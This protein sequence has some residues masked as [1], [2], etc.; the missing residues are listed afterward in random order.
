MDVINKTGLVA[1]SKEKS[2]STEQIELTKLSEALLFTSLNSIS[3]SKNLIVVYPENIF[4]SATFLGYNFMKTKK[5]DVLFF[6]SDKGT[7][8][9]NPFKIHLE[10]FCMLQEKNAPWF[11]WHSYLPCTLKEDHLDINIIFRKGV[12]TKTK[13]TEILELKEKLKNDEMGFNRFIFCTDLTNAR[14]LSK[15]KSLNFDKNIYNFKERLG[16]CIFENLSNKVTS[17]QEIDS[18]TEWLKPLSEKN[19]NF[20]FHISNFIDMNIIEYFKNKTDSIVLYL[21]PELLNKGKKFFYEQSPLLS[22]KKDNLSLKYNLDSDLIY[23]KESCDKKIIEIENFHYTLKDI[24]KLLFEVSKLNKLPKQLLSRIKKIIFLLPKLTVNPISWGRALYYNF[25]DKGPK[26]I[27]IIE[28]VNEINKYKNKSDKEGYDLI[29]NLKHELLSLHN[30][31]AETDRFG[32][33]HPFKIQTKPYKIIEL[34]NELIKYKDKTIIIG[35]Y[36]SSER[37]VLNNTIKSILPNTNNIN[38]KTLNQ[39]TNLANI[40]PNTKLILPSYLVTRYISEFFKPYDEIIIITYAGEEKEQTQKEIN[41]INQ[42]NDLYINQSIDYFNKLYDSLNWKKDNFIEELNKF[43]IVDLE[44]DNSSSNEKLTKNVV[45]K[46]KSKILEDKDLKKNEELFDDS[47]DEVLIDDEYTSIEK[48]FSLNLSSIEDSLFKRI[49]LLKGATLLTINNDE[50]IEEKDIIELNEGD[51]IVLIQG[52]ERKSFIDYLA[53]RSGLE[54]EIDIFHIKIWKDKLNIFMDKNSLNEKELF[55][56]YIEHG[57]DIT[58]NPFIRWKDSVKNIA[59]RRKEDLIII[60]KIID[61]ETLLENID[62]VFDD[63]KKLRKFHRAIGREINKIIK[64]KLSGNFVDSSF[65]D[66]DL[67]NKLKIFK[68]DKITKND[69]KV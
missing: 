51:L 36:D 55:N 30:R 56:K 7:F 60:A 44:D 12:K 2:S 45:D 43:K 20:I 42:T 25:E 28:L 3:K 37:R 67:S 59:P 58:V 64:N 61:Y 16:L 8:Q 40:P 5:Q 10:N 66:F 34:V 46:I 31:F 4:R 65:D 33:K 1:Y 52:D 18:F 57:G 49:E 26:H 35:V 21:S 38:V 50:E 39:I 9:E 48:D 53:K 32:E 14:K 41:I 23:Q 11:L 19:I 47:Q 27:S 17:Y 69:Q 54:D 63:I 15:I 29:N 13:Q 62:E 24:N 6:T 68:I 22:K